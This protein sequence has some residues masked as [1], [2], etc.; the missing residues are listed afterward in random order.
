[1][2]TNSFGTGMTKAEHVAMKRSAPIRGTMTDL[3][4]A[5][6]TLICSG[7]CGHVTD[8]D[9]CRDT[10]EDVRVIGGRA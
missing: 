1:M 5:A 9:E 7:S 6:G 4:A 8:L 3:A 2:K 10:D